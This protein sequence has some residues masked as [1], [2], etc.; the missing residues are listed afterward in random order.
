MEHSAKAHQAS[1]EAV[2]K[3]AT[4]LQGSEKKK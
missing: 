4:S 2:Q 3:S 1:P